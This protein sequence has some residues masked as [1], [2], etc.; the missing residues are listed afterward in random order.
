MK[1]AGRPSLPY[2]APTQGCK[3]GSL[4]WSRITMPCLQHIRFENLRNLLNISMA[5]LTTY[6]VQIISPSIFTC[7]SKLYSNFDS[8]ISIVKLFSSHRKS[9]LEAV[10]TRSPRQVRWIDRLP[11]LGL[12]NRASWNI[13]NRKYRDQRLQYWKHKRTLCGKGGGEIWELREDPRHKSINHFKHQRHQEGPWREVLLYDFDPQRVTQQLHQLE[14][15]WLVIITTSDWI[16]QQDFCISTDCNYC[17][18][19]PYFLVSFPIILLPETIQELIRGGKLVQNV[20]QCR[21]TSWLHC[22]LISNG[23]FFLSK[24]Y[25]LLIRS[26][27]SNDHD[28]DS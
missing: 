7:L 20:S 1:T 6:G 4:D 17:A 2:C 27:Q 15:F 13:Y 24:T 10:T 9:R 21:K 14:S 5:R 18:L 12:R 23:Y 22:D 8:R 25:E 19:Q 3:V 26:L 28:D 16:F 11:D